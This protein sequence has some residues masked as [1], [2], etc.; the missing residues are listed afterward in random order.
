[1]VATASPFIASLGSFS[2]M[3]ALFGSPLFM[4]ADSL[5]NYIM[6]Y[7]FLNGKIG[8]E[9]VLYL[10]I[11]MGFVIE[12]MAAAYIIVKTTQAVVSFVEGYAFQYRGGS[13]IGN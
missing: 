11:A 6:M 12:L 4:L 10:G 1:M 7:D 9:L 5:I 13:I 2:A 3:A 8:P